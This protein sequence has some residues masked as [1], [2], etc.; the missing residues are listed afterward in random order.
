MLPQIE[1]VAEDFQYDSSHSL[2]KI[3]KMN[4]KPRGYCIIINIRKNRT[5]TD[6]DVEKLKKLFKYL[7]FE[8]W[9]YHELTSHEIT[10]LTELIRKTDHEKLSTFVMFVLAHGNT[11]NGETV[12][13]AEDGKHVYVSKIEKDMKG[14]KGLTGKPKLL[15]IQACRGT[16]SDQGVEYVEEIDSIEDEEH[17]IQINT[18]I[19]RDSDFLKLMPQQREKLLLAIHKKEPYL[20]NTW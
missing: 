6:K 7:K 20:F 9:E 16:R 13:E 17:D 4:T 10:Q 18:L 8:V 12:I 3:Y 2:K 1:N 14:A 15:F 5:G 11:V 19:A